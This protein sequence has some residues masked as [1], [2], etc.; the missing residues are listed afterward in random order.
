MSCSVESRHEDNVLQFSKAW[1]CFLQRPSQTVDTMQNL[2]VCALVN[3]SK[4]CL[5]TLLYAEVS[6][7][8]F[9]CR[10]EG[11]QPRQANAL[12]NEYMLAKLE[13]HTPW[14]TALALVTLSNTPIPGPDLDCVIS[15]H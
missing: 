8:S 3:Y 10:L 14:V 4:Q 9:K 5:R 12:K 2:P 15:I 6:Q 11:G 1:Q 7:Q 13:E